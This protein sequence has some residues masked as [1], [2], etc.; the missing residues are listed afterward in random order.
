MTR[1]ATLMACVAVVGLVHRSDASTLDADM[2]ADLTRTCLY[3]GCRRGY[4]PGVGLGEL[5]RPII[6]PHSLSL[7]KRG[8]SE[9]LCGPKG[10]SRA[11][12]I[13]GPCFS[14]DLS[15]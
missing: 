2:V 9:V 11:L 5:G 15:H 10:R 6:C 7:L 12:V 1:H 14:V 4:R 13:T 3:L 8:L